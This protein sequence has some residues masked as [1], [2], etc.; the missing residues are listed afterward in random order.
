MEEMGKK[1]VQIYSSLF[2]CFPLG[3]KN[4]SKMYYNQW[5]VCWPQLQ[6]KYSNYCLCFPQNVFLSSSV[7]VTVNLRAY[8]KCWFYF[9]EFLLIPFTDSR[10]SAIL[11]THNFLLELGG[12]KKKKCFFIIISPLSKQPRY[13]NKILIRAYLNG[14]EDYTSGV[15]SLIS[16]FLAPEVLRVWGCFL[17]Q[18]VAPHSP[19]RKWYHFL[20]FNEFI[21]DILII[22]A[23]WRLDKETSAPKS[24]ICHWCFSQV[25][26]PFTIKLLHSLV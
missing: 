22:Y 17:P 7:C 24:G 2:S 1:T 13:L 11:K 15:S 20:F 21:C 4:V 10:S 8:V 18:A 25:N 23:K 9:S 14:V 16:C 3:K 19:L 12:K 26:F 5:V 6:V